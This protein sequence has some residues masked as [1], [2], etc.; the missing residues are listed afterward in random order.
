MSDYILPDTE[1]SELRQ[2]HA[3]LRDK[4]EADQVKAIILLG[5]QQTLPKRFSL[6]A[7]RSAPTAGNIRNAG[8]VRRRRMSPLFQAVAI[9]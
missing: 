7:I 8:Q 3:E 9:R 5:W 1:L 4:R 6:T 2:A